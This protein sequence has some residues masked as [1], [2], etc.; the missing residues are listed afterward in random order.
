MLA[1]MGWSNMLMMLAQSSTGLVETWFLAKLGTQVLAGIAVVV[2][3]LMLMQNM[4]QGAMGGGISSAVAR[5]LGSGNAALINQL[6][7]HA[8]A[9][10]AVQRFHG[11]ISRSAGVRSMLPD[12][13]QALWNKWVMLA[14]GALMTCLMRGTVGE[15]LASQDGMQLM[16]QAIDEC[17]TISATEDHPLSADELGRIRAR[18][19]DPQSTWAASMMRDIASSAPRVEADAIVGDLLVRA[20]R[21]KIDLPLAR[22]AYCHLQV[23]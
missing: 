23:Y 2:P 21:H 6:A 17:S 1:G 9:L 4:S 11:L 18:L 12:I 22:V 3:L 8:V 19:L 7:R 13:E 14:A 10:N 20:K 16:N 15:I 5:S